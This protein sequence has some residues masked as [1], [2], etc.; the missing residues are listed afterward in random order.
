MSLPVKFADIQNVLIL[1][2][3]HLG[4]LLLST[5]L[6][7][8][9]RTA[10]PGRHFTLVASPANAGALGGWDALDEIRVF[11]S[12]WPLVRKREFVRELRK[13]RWDLC[14][15][16]SPRTP[17]YV[18]GFLS[19]APIRAGIIYSRRLMARLLSP[20]W[21]T[22][23]VV[24]DVDEQLSAGQ[25]VPHEVKQLAKIATILGI[26]AANP[27]PLEFPLAAGDVAWAHAWLAEHEAGYIVGIHGAGKWLSQGWTS[28][29]FLSLAHAVA[30]L[31]PETKVLLTFGPGDTELQNA[32][33]DALTLS[34]NA[35]V[36][37]PGQLSIPRWAA[38]FSLCTV[39]ISPDTGSLHLAVALGCP[40]VAMYEA[41]TF[42]HCSS[43]WAP[44]QVPSGT[45]R[46]GAPDET[47]PLL[48][49]ET[50]RLIE[51]ENT[52]S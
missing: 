33:E 37:I 19:G 21:L 47:L 8:T 50:M 6:I 36:L 23:A 29:D 14:L 2:T 45:V 25:S 3:D 11:D 13:T 7:R 35:K 4:D 18:L 27:G 40:V 41:D 5:P 43:Q 31:R 32:V 17:S 39:V 34:P 20:L 42:L 15:T 30:A 44:W 38:L 28:S 24:W 52:F 1:R 46:R 51:M 16:L 12:R 48:I 10:L 9:M 22:H 26:P 49:G